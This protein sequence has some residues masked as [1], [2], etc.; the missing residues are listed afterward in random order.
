ML[1]LIGILTFSM[2]ANS[3]AATTWFAS[4]YFNTDTFP[5]PKGIDNQLFY[6]QRDPDANTVI[7]K[8][9]IKDGQLINNEPV[10]GFWIRYAENGQIKELSGIQKKLAYGIQSK[11]IEKGKYELRIISYPRFPLYLVQ[12][13]VG[14]RYYVYAIVKQRQLILNKVFVRIKGGTFW[15]PKVAYIELSGKDGET[16]KDLTHR[17]TI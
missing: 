11:L 3:R 7:Y 9:N 10:S 12:S 16:G 5:I 13:P 6:L 17:I 4:S 2:Q 8:L 1:I 14:G 15:F